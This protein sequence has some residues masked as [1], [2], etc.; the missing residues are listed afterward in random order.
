MDPSIGLHVGIN[1]FVASG[2]WMGLMAYPAVAA[3]WTVGPQAQ[4]SPSA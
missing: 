1:R 3:V 4:H 2:I